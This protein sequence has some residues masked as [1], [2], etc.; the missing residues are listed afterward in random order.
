MYRVE[1]KALLLSVVHRE[2]GICL[3]QIVDED[4][5]NM[6]IDNIF[7]HA[8][9]TMHRELVSKGYGQS[10]ACTA[11]ERFPEMEEIQALLHVAGFELRYREVQGSAG[12]EGVLMFLVRPGKAPLEIQPGSLA[13]SLGWWQQFVSDMLTGA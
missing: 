4:D 6:R 12:V 13:N 8:S 10:V 3:D 2:A 11:S 5:G 1:S 9:V 7:E